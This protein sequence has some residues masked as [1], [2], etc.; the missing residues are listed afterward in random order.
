M[1]CS[2][3]LYG[4][5]ADYQESRFQASKR[6]NMCSADL[7]VGRFA[8]IYEVCFQA[9]K[10]SEMDCVEVQGGLFVDSQGWHFQL[11]KRS[12]NC[13]TILQ[14]DRFAYVHEEWFHGTKL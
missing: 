10:H 1:G 6:S 5:F 4:R 7:E 2:A 3:L 12:D 11:S 13:S 8:D 9:S 14:E